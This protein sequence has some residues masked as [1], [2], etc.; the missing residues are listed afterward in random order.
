MAPKKKQSDIQL[1][2]GNKSTRILNEYE[3]EV[4]NELGLGGASMR[5]WDIDF[6]LGEMRLKDARKEVGS[7]C[8][9]G[10]VPVVKD[11]ET[12]VGATLSFSIA[13]HIPYEIRGTAVG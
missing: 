11:E 2:G 1:N 6:G 10:N 7:G 12:E 4:P 3:V 13:T 5:V 9:I 8:D